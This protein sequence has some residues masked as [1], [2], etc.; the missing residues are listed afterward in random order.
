[1]GIIIACY[2]R[3]S[4]IDESIASSRSNGF[5]LKGSKWNECFYS[6]FGAPKMLDKLLEKGLI[7]LP[8]L[9]RPKEMGRTNDLKYY[10]YHMILSHP[11]EKC[12]AFR[13]QSL[14]LIEGGKFKLDEEDIEEFD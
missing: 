6:E 11:I 5:K 10:K 4:N 9:K 2:E 7:R 13:G 1:V 12:K 3:G 8:E 14:Q